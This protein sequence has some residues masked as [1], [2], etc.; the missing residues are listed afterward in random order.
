MCLSFCSSAP[1]HPQEELVA[2]KEPK[3]VGCAHKSSLELAG[4]QTVKYG[5]LGGLSLPDCPGG[6]D[7]L[8]FHPH[9][10]I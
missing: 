10:S 6:I 7:T 8:P 1:E 9:S 3:H 2:R 4:N 5:W